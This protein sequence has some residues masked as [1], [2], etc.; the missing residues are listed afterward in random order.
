[1][2]LRLR[3]LRIDLSHFIVPAIRFLSSGDKTNTYVPQN[4]F[5]ATIISFFMVLAQL[6]LLVRGEATHHDDDTRA[7]DVHMVS[8]SQKL[9][10]ARGYV[11]DA[12]PFVLGLLHLTLVCI[13]ISTSGAS[14]NPAR[15]FGVAVISGQWVHHWVYWA[16]PYGGAILAALAFNYFGAFPKESRSHDE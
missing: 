1:M 6:M 11:K 12:A 2:K 8:E 4:L 9:R 14:M 16:G 7:N 3:H 15:S 10:E 5:S 13:S